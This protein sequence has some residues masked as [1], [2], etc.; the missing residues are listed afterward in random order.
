MKAFL[1]LYYVL[2]ITCNQWT[3]R[4][5]KV[6]FHYRSPIE[7]DTPN[8]ANINPLCITYIHLTDLSKLNWR[9]VVTKDTISPTTIGKIIQQIKPTWFW[10]YCPLLMKSN[11]RAWNI[12]LLTCL[13]LVSYMSIAIKISVSKQIRF[14]PSTQNKESQTNT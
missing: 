11:E 4:S 5:N 12:S 2:L 14:T 6:R 10:K 9:V 1:S 3:Q 7:I 8:L 13:I